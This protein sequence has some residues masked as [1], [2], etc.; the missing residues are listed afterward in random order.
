MPTDPLRDLEA[1]RDVV[2]DASVVIALLLDEPS[3]DAVETV[4]ATASARM[5]AV[6]AAEAVDALLRVYA[7]TQEDVLARVDELLSAVPFAPATTAVATRAGELR[8]RLWR[9]DRRIA[10]A[11]CFCLA[12]AEPGDRIATLDD[13]LA[14]VGRAEGYEVVELG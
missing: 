13:R 7:G 10:L 2:L 1:G 6:N 9:R 4:L 14:A 8:A 5:S 12:T 11:D 3:A